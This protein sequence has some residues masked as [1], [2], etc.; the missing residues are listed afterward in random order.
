AQTTPAQ[1]A[2]RAGRLFDPRSG[3]HLTNQVVIVSRDRIVEVGPADRV[4]I[5]AGA[6]VIDLS[7]AT[8]LP[9]LIDAHVHVMGG[10][11]GLQYQMLL[12]VANAQKDLR[13]GFTTLVDLGSHGGG[14]GT[15]D[16]RKAIDSGLVQG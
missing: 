14:Y 9:G 8:V 1:V 3:A 4:T 15:V 5:P 10:P 7:Q 13:A 11:S 2:I 12:G 16:L 6:S